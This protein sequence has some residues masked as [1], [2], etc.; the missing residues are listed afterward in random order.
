M[1]EKNNKKRF[2]ISVL[3]ICLAVIALAC[4]FCG[5]KAYVKH[6]E[7][8][9]QETITTTNNEIEK[10]NDTF[11]GTDDRSAKL[12]A[13]KN[14]T[15]KYEDY[16]KSDETFDECLKNYENEIKTEK[17]YFENDYVTS[18]INCTISDINSVSN[19]DDLN[20]LITNLNGFKENLKNEYENYST[21]SEEKFNELNIKVDSLINTYTERVNAIVAAEEEAKR[22]AEEEARKQ[23]EAEAAAK[24]EE[25]KTS[26]SNSKS[27]NSSS[28]KSNNSSS[29]KSS[30]SSNSSSKS[31]SGSGSSSSSN[32]YTINGTYTQD[33]TGKKHNWSYNPSTGDLIEDGVKEN[34]KENGYFN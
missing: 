33:Q 9:K 17:S 31:N 32:D 12:E 27:S 26:N 13:L 21:I 1:K 22:Q 20:N 7:E 29:S 28:S 15:T 34:T 19:K 25:S 11:N 14:T 30:S 4:G 23:A 2:K 24:A 8:V 10:L 16:K 5:K 18:I 6:L 3:I